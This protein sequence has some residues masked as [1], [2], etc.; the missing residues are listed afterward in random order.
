MFLSGDMECSVS[1]R[2]LR[3]K[4]LTE[5]LMYCAGHR[6]YRGGV[7]CLLYL[8]CSARLAEFYALQGAGLHGIHQARSDSSLLHGMDGSNRG[9]AGA[10]HRVL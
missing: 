9:A 2:I 6:S 10:G 7:Q 1:L 5:R 4:L 3:V 8:G